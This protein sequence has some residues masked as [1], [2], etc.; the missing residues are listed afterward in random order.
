MVNQEM[1]GKL[2]QRS[3]AV[4]RE[5]RNQPGRQSLKE[6]QDM[7]RRRRRRVL[8]QRIT[9]LTAFLVLLGLGAGIVGRRLLVPS[10]K[11]HSAL[12]GAGQPGGGENLSGLGEGD[13]SGSGGT[14]TAPGTSL[15][16]SGQSGSDIGADGQAGADGAASG[17]S[18]SDTGADGQAGADGAASGQ[19]GSDMGSGGQA[20]ENTAG[21]SDMAPGASA[22]SVDLSGIY[23]AYALLTGRDTGAVIGE[24][25]SKDR[26]Y[27]ASM[28]KIMTAILAIEETADL[29]ASVT[30]PYEIY[31]SLYAEGASMAGFEP[32]ETATLEDL[33]YGILLPSGA[34]CCLTF[35][36]RIAGSEAAFA[37]L[38]NQK[39][40]ELGMADTHFCNSTGLHDP[41]HYTTVADI[42]VLLRY[43][44][45]NPTFR[46]IFTSSRH[47]VSPTA[48]HPEGFTFFSTM[49][50]YMSTAEVT[51]GEILGGKTGY[52]EEA[53]LCLASLASVNGKEYIL[54][55]AKADGSHETEQFHILDAQNVYSQLGAL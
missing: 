5:M 10:E 53:G 25:N 22:V 46:E 41:N 11:Y 20:G 37:E 9:M 48:Q 40:A 55:T 35:V 43:A 38:M 6:R 4:N 2:S 32:G 49:F 8:V 51:G 30:L 36:N 23:S 18:G 24:R 33:V 34:E 31:D 17:Q 14:G 42:A 54:V 1:R 26:I 29:S 19:S 3:P 13:V 45:D 15:N 44:L 7:R 28:T 16:A 50:Q 47:S 27:P 12:E 39:A 21:Q 52:T